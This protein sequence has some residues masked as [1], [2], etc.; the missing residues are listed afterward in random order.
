MQTVDEVVKVREGPSLLPCAVDSVPKFG[1]EAADSVG[2]EDDAKALTKDGE[3]ASVVDAGRFD[4]GSVAARL[5]E[6]VLG[7]V[8]ASAVVD[9]GD[10]ERNRKVGLEVEALEALDRVRGGMPLGEGVAGEAFD[11][12]PDF[13]GFFGSITA[14]G[15]VG[16]KLGFYCLKFSAGAEFTGHSAP[17]DV[18]LGK[19]EA[20]VLVGHADDVFLVNHNAVG[21]GKDAQEFG[22]GL[23]AARG[24]AVAVDVGLHH[25]R[26]RDAGANDRAGRDELEV[27]R[28]LELGHEHAHGRGFDVEAAHGS[29]VAKEFEAVR[30]VFEPVAV[31]NVRGGDGRIPQRSEGFGNFTESALA[32]NVEF[33]KPHVLGCVHVKVHGWEALGRHEGG[34]PRGEWCIGDEDSAGMQRHTVGK[35]VQQAS[36]AK[37]VSGRVVVVAQLAVGQLVDVGFGQAPDFSQFAHDRAVLK[38][39]DSS[40]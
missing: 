39:A 31:V 4:A 34:R 20:R 5:L 40:E 24:I 18:G 2:S 3:G 9:V 10:H 36:V 8:V 21:F 15:A 12:A 38:G 14:L 11:L 17:K 33:V 19:R 1:V 32:Q 7:A 23:S 22:V 13:A 28:G 37:D 26:G 35:P 29:A 25:S 30:V 6:V 16:E 27:V